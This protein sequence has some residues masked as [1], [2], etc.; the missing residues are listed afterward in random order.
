MCREIERQRAAF[1]GRRI[2]TSSPCGYREF[3][4]IKPLLPDRGPVLRGG[5]TS[6]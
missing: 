6:P 2:G 5:V 3:H 4:M 1:N